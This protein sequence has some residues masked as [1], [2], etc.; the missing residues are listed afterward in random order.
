MSSLPKVIY[1]MGPP[2][3]GK[4][5]Q[6]ELL[7]QEIGYHRFSTGD[8]FRTLSREDSPLGREV[9]NLIDNGI[10]APPPLAAKI[11]IAAITERLKKGEGLIFDGTPRTLEEAAIV[12][13]FFLD[14]GYGK[15]LAIVLTIDKEEMIRRN[16]KRRFCLGIAGD[17]PILTA[18]D[19]QRC[20][21]LG[22]HIGI[23]PDDEPAKFAARWQ[24]FTNR[25]YPVIEKYRREGVAHEID[26]AKSIEAVHE[27]VMKLIES[28]TGNS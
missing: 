18:A 7:A 1:V 9:K 4:G 19:K 20:H 23:R 15:P 8:A 3:A 6:A 2:G 22:G 13:Q 25:A 12:D 24:Q 5:T 21:Q 16:S 14:N 11:V 26:G 10:F 17:F 28:V 27:D